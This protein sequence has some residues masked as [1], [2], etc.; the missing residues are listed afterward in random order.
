MMQLPTASAIP[1]PAWR[2]LQKGRFRAVLAHFWEAEPLPL[3]PCSQ[4]DIGPGPSPVPSVRPHRGSGE[5]QKCPSAGQGWGAAGAREAGACSASPWIAE[6]RGEE[7]SSSSKLSEAALGTCAAQDTAPAP[8]R[9]GAISHLSAPRLI[10]VQ[11]NT[12]LGNRILMLNRRCFFPWVSLTS[13]PEV[14]MA[15]EV[16]QR[17]AKEFQLLR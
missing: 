10:S 9:P 2:L 16:T 14:S 4:K 5:S 15:M 7:F 8:A 3:P 12:A 13:Y 1:G 11:Q 6:E 17:K